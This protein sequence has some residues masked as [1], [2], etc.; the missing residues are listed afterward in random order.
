MH[1]LVRTDPEAPK[2]RGITYLL[3]PLRDE[4]GEYL[5]GITVRGIPDALGR[6]RWDEIFLE[7]VHVPS[8]NIIGEEN[9]GWYAAMTTLSFERSNIEGPA[10]LIRI[11]EDFIAYARRLR[12]HGESPLDNP[13]VRHQIADLR[14][15]IETMRMLS[16]RVGWMPL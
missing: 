3:M 9:R 14:L 7:N 16:Y 8:N 4:K 12:R 11:L 5:P 2:H 6:H 13:I 1:I 10:M 15:E